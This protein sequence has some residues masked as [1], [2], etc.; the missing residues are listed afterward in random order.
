VLVAEIEREKAEDALRRYGAS[1]YAVLPQGSTV[2][3]LTE[4]IGGRNC[5]NCGA[6]PVRED[7]CAYCGTLVVH[8]AIKP[9]MPP[10]QLWR[11]G[12]ATPMLVTPTMG[13]RISR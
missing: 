12:R 8:H 11:D 9:E 3:T 2:V 5:R 7:A 10:N 4:A 6:P 1:G 13:Q